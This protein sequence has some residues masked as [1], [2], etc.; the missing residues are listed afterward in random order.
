MTSLPAERQARKGLGAFYSPRSLVEPMVSWAVT[1]PSTSVLDPSCGD[2]VFVELAAERLCELGA[3]P[4][5]AAELIHAIDLNPQAA[6]MTA[7]TLSRILGV[8]LEA[9][10]QS[11]FSLEPPGTLFSTQVPVD[12][13]IG[14]PPYI[15]YQEFT[16]LSRREALARA[17]GAGVNLT[18]LASSWAHF[19]AHAVTFIKPKGRLALILPAELVHAAYS[20]PLR[21]FLRESFADVAVISFRRAVFPGAQESVVILLASG[22]GEPHQRLGL[23]AVE[24]SQDLQSLAEV[25]ARAEVFQNGSEPTK[26][27]PGHT[28]N[29]SALFLAR[30]QK[31]G[32]FCPLGQVGKVSIG[33]VSGANDFFVL[34]PKGAGALGL[35]K[36]SLRPALVRARQIPSFL[37]TRKDIAAMQKENQRCLLWLPGQSLTRAEKAYARNG[38]AEGI[39]ERYKCRVRT[40]WYVV[41]GVVVPEAFLTYMSDTVPRLCLNAAAAATANTLLAVRLPHVPVGLRKAFVVAFYNSATMLS[42]ERTGRSYGGGVLKLEPREADQVLVPS[43]ALVRQHRGELLALGPRLHEALL[44]GRATQIAEALVAVDKVLLGSRMADAQDLSEER[45]ALAARRKLRASSES[46]VQEMLA[47]YG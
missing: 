23:V 2:G 10:A 12:T 8:P 41:P 3:S 29:R 11:F 16:G 44:H 43:V 47:F 40:P 45:A 30:L 5:S 7:E 19:V 46:L 36:R 17:T 24:S 39:H 6:R 37:L 31:D 15:R 14:N 20:A 27:V 22:K 28:G 34:T 9:R 21:R 35:P 32:L 33:F 25:L 18:R 26:W 38:E 13:V 1:T 4:G 42:C